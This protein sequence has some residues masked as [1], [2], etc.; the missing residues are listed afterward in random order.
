MP[1]NWKSRDTHDV[2]PAMPG[3]K[4][5]QPCSA[6]GCT[7]E[8]SVDVDFREVEQTAP[9]SNELPGLCIRCAAPLGPDDERLCLAC[10][11]DVMTEG[12]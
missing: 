1:S 11:V 4:A 6:C 7:G 9:P 5:H 8:H 2:R 3:T 10:Y 12:E